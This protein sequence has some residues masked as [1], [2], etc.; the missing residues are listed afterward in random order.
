MGAARSCGGLGPAGMVAERGEER[1]EVSGPGGG[2]DVHALQ[3]EAPVGVDDEI[4]E[5]AARASRS[6]SS[7]GMTWASARHR[8]AST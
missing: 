2:H 1:T 6:A 5:P 4:A 3:V 8:N 7:R